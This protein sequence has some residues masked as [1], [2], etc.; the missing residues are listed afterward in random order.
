MKGILLEEKK[1]RKVG[2][3]FKYLKD[4]QNTFDLTEII[5]GEA[6]MAPSP[7]SKHQKAVFLLGMLIQKCAQEKGLGE[8][9][10]SPLDVILEEGVNRL[11]PD[12]IFIKNENLGI[13]QDWIRGAPDLVVEI[14]SK[15]SITVDSV[16]KKEIYERYGVGEFWLVLPEEKTIQVYSLENNR[17]KIFSFAEEEGTVKSHVIGGLVIDIKDVFKE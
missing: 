3:N 4:V 5:N 9:Y 6:V 10:V 7:F 16:I 1:G 8:V 15:G 14:A 11:Q 17:Y 13:V 12:L 2:E